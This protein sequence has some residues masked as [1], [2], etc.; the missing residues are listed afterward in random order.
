M[1]YTIAFNK[2]RPKILFLIVLITLDCLRVLRVLGVLR[3]LK[4]LRMLRILRMR[5]IRIIR[6]PASHGVMDQV[7]VFSTIDGPVA[8]MMDF[9]VE[10][11][12]VEPK[13]SS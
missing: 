8:R 7:G 6:V 2:I 3:M 5:R 13:K 1:L 4:V 11:M 10:L 9:R 12:M